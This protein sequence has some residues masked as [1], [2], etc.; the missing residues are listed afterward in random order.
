MLVKSNSS[1]IA[2]YTAVK[3]LHDFT[4]PNYF[5]LKIYEIE[6]KKKKKSLKI[7]EKKKNVIKLFTTNKKEK[8]KFLKD[9]DMKS[10]VL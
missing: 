10:I 9:I 4:K 7:K 8:K 1:L 3:S 5:T 6:S 2:V